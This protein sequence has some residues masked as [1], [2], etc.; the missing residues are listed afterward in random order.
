M[1]RP[2]FAENVERSRFRFEEQDHGAPRDARE[3]KG[4]P[5]AERLEIGAAGRA[6]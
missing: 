1:G 6:V 4:I 5:D 3:S 2:E